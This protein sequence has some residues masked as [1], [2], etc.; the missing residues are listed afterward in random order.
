MLTLRILPSTVEAKGTK[1]S[2]TAMT[3]DKSDFNNTGGKIDDANKSVLYHNLFDDDNS[4]IPIDY[5]SH[6][7]TL[8]PLICPRDR[9]PPP[10]VHVFS[11]STSP[12]LSVL[13]QLLLL[14]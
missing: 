4:H 6:S 2:T 12:L 10:W 8:F 14:T 9:I 7:G 3:V 11:K 1:A 13:K 5:A